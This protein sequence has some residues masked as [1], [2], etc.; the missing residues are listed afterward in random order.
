MPNQNFDFRFASK[1]GNSK[2]FTPCEIGNRIIVM[3]QKLP[4]VFVEFP[5]I[6]PVEKQW[7]GSQKC[8]TCRTNLFDN[9]FEEKRFCNTLTVVLSTY[10]NPFTNLSATSVQPSPV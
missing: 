5:A 9:D 10:F 6:F 7:A 1:I 3:R 8:D 2:I 4:A